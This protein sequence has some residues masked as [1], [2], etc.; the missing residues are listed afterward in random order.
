MTAGDPHRRYQEDDRPRR[1]D[2]KTSGARDSRGNGRFG[3][4]WTRRLRCEALLLENFN[5][6]RLQAATHD[7][8]VRS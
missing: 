6:E 2:S 5:G 8:R 1:D 4:R 3:W 7:T